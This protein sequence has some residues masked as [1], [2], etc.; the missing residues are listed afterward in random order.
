MSDGLDS[1][2]SLGRGFSAELGELAD[3]DFNAADQPGARQADDQVR[4]FMLH[5]HRVRCSNSSACRVVGRS[6]RTPC[7]VSSFAPRAVQTP[8]ISRCVREWII[9]IPFLT[10]LCL[11]FVEKK[12]G[13][14][15]TDVIVH[16]SAGQKRHR[17]SRHGNV[18]GRG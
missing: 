2:F 16:A 14:R 12:Y 17:R 15:H 3:F 9:C 13:S 10:P 4:R 8:D 6:G 18:R 11:R 7:K 1:A 5:F